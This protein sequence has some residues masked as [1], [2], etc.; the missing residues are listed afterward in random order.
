MSTYDLV[1][2]SR[3]L[4][5]N[6]IFSA[7]GLTLPKLNWDVGEQPIIIKPIPILMELNDCKYFR[8][9]VELFF[10]FSWIMNNLSIASQ[11]IL[12]MQFQPFFH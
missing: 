9:L 3:V 1:K 2:D 7:T 4:A 12:S 11:M 5:K 10:P 6:V 8:F